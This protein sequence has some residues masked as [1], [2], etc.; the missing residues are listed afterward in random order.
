MA[1]YD[2]VSVIALDFTK[3]FDTVRHATLLH[4]MANIGIPDVVYAVADETLFEHVLHNKQ[5]VLHQLLPGQNA[6]NLQPSFKKT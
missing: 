1:S 5:H 6:I 3:A 4:K 2:S